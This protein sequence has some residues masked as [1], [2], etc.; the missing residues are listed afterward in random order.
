MF[1]V[2]LEYLELCPVC[3]DGILMKAK[4]DN[5]KDESQRLSVYAKRVIPQ[6]P[7]KYEFCVKDLNTNEEICV[8]SGITKAEVKRIGKDRGIKKVTIVEVQPE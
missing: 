8:A 3:G 6:R 4:M 1:P 2:K 5:T 7:I